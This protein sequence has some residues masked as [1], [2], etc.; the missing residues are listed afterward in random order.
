MIAPTDL[1]TIAASGTLDVVGDGPADG[2]FG[3]EGFATSL[4]VRDPDGNVVE[5]RCLLSSARAPTQSVR[6][7]RFW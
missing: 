2:L 6:R 5:L 3:A 7:V 1:A 4:Y